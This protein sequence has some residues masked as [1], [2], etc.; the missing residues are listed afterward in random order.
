MTKR[1]VNNVESRLRQQVLSGWSGYG[2]PDGYSDS[3][4]VQQRE[5]KTSPN[6][7]EQKS[8]IAFIPVI[9]EPAGTG[10]DGNEYSIQVAA[11]VDIPLHTFSRRGKN[12]SKSSVSI[13]GKK[14]PAYHSI[15]VVY[16]IQQ[17]GDDTLSHPTGYTTVQAIANVYSGFLGK[18]AT[19]LKCLL[20]HTEG[21]APGTVDTGKRK[22]GTQSPKD[23]GEPKKSRRS[24]AIRPKVRD[25]TIPEMP[26][27]LDETNGS[28]LGHRPE[29]G[30]NRLV[31]VGN[32]PFEGTGLEGVSL[33]F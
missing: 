17:N 25:E 4:Q 26:A 14:G 9:I 11:N 19:A 3:N 18:V 7:W 8:Y 20:Q 22:E 2:Q 10:S 6:F 12:I 21:E 29:D 32:N 5:E 15:P 24:G 16:G 13:P 23:L 28:I 30:T 31:E 33:D 27:K 1:K